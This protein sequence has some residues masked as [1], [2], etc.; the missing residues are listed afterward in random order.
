MLCAMS[1]VAQFEYG[2]NENVD[3]TNQIVMRLLIILRTNKNEMGFDCV[4][5][6]EC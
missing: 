2:L 5:R 3:A 4:I 1:D 6:K